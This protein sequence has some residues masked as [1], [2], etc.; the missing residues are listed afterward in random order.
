MDQEAWNQIYADLD[1]DVAA[2]RRRGGTVSDVEVTLAIDRARFAMERGDSEEAIARI[3]ELKRQLR[4]PDVPVTRSTPP[5]SSPALDRLD[6][7]EDNLH[8]ET[9]LGSARLEIVGEDEEEIA[10]TR[11][12]SRNTKVARSIKYDE[13]RDEYLKLW[14]SCQIRPERASAVRREADRLLANRKVY[15]EIQAETSVPWWFVGLLHQMECSY[16]LSKHLHNGDSLKA[17]T[18]QVPAGRPKDGSPPFEFAESAVDALEVDGF[19]GKTDWPL[20]LCLWRMERYNGFGYRRKFGFASPYLWSFT[21]H[22]TAGKYVKDGVFDA[23]APSKQCGTAA[24][25]RDLMQRG[26]VSF[27]EK[28]PEVVAQPAPKPAEQP[29]PS[30]PAKP[31]VAA[32]SPAVPPPSPSA[33]TPVPAA[34]PVAAP[35]ATTPHTPAPAAPA[36]PAPTPAPVPANT[37]APAGAQAASAPISPATGASSP[38]SA[39]P[40]AT[41]APAAP[42]PAPA[43]SPVTAP[44]APSAAAAATAQSSPPATPSPP[45]ASAPSQAQAQTPPPAETAAQ[46]APAVAPPASPEASA[47]A[48]PVS[49]P[50]NPPAVEPSSAVVSPAVAAALAELA[51]RGRS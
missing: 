5:P 28:K 17:R 33:E 51:R 45:P 44:V 38:A 39:A 42:A 10:V 6:A 4:G 26:L 3:Q 14:N 35:I 16:S 25:L 40:T 27:D 7:L 43:P 20:A 15:E 18:W 41:P 1:S 2:I 37:P 34:T 47:S 9:R 11:S 12:A 8:A 36:A 21:S 19:A 46:Q 13:I 49:T 31:E 48:T 23:N 24:T 32:Q 29:K 50:P 30:E 22:F